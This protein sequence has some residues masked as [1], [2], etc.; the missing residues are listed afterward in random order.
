MKADIVW[1]KEFEN[2]LAVSFKFEDKLMRTSLW[3]GDLSQNIHAARVVVVRDGKDGRR[4]PRS[5]PAEQRAIAA[6][7]AAVKAANLNVPTM[8]R[9]KS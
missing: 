4:L 2:V 1:V 5:G 7:I 9:S 8:Q 6:V 3:L